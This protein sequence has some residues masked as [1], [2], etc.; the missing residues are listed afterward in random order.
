MA[1]KIKFEKIQ[2]L[3]YAILPEYLE[4]GGDFGDCLMVHNTPEMLDILSEGGDVVEVLIDNKPI[5]D[6]DIKFL[7]SKID[8]DW[9][10]YNPH[11]ENKIKFDKEIGLCPVNLFVWGGTHPD[12][13]YIKK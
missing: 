1:F 2:G 3:W 5:V 9:G 7:L 10:F 8:S 12:F 13:I 11:S 4:A 6:C